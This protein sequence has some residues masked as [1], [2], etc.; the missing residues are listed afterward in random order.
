[1]QVRF[2]VRP[3]V[4]LCVFAFTYAASGSTCFS[5]LRRFVLSGFPVDPHFLDFGSALFVMG[6][7]ASW[8]LTSSYFI[9]ALPL[10]W[11]PSIVFACL[12]GFDYACTT[13]LFGL[14][15][16]YSLPHGLGA[17]GSPL[18]HF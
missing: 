7:F 8:D 9:L 13:T 15:H 3:F 4:N 1:M 10:G 14:Q 2:I 12:S 17:H 18:Q 6:M 5:P 16:K 11:F